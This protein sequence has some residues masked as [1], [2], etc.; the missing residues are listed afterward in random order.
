M[1]SEEEEAAFF[2]VAGGGLV[3]LPSVGV[4]TAVDLS[5]LI[6]L[7]GGGD[8]DCSAALFSGDLGFTVGGV[9]GVGLFGGV[10]VCM[11]K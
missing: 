1:L 8:E 2:V 11:S 7:A 9:G 3:V 10:G 5:A 4:F 6:E